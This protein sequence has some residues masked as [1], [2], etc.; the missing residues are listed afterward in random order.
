MRAVSATINEELESIIRHA[1]EAE[2]ELPNGINIDYR[3]GITN[4]IYRFTDMAVEL[5]NNLR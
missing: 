5:L 4:G 2:L 3:Y 1:I